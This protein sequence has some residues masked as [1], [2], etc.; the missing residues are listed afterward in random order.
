LKGTLKRAVYTS[1][2]F[3]YILL[4][5]EA[6]FVF[7]MRME[8]ANLQLL[9]TMMSFFFISL[10]SMDLSKA[11]LLE[12]TN[13]HRS[14]ELQNFCTYSTKWLPITLKGHSSATIVSVMLWTY[15]ASLGMGVLGLMKLSY[16]DKQQLSINLDT[17]L[18]YKPKKENIR[19][20]ISSKKIPEKMK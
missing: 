1:L 17:E 4:S 18:Y 9:G 8:S 10:R 5:K 2:N 19:N 7:T 16:T 12:T 3:T 15:V 11:L 20:K 14:F 6:T 13:T